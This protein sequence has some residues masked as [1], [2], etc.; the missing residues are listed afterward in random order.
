MPRRPEFHV[1]GAWMLAA[2]RICWKL[3]N[4]LSQGNLLDAAKC[5][6]E[7]GRAMPAEKLAN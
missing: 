6:E 7:E 3:P 4:S 1:V 5:N 2:R